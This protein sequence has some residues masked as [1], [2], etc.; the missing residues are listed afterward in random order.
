MSSPCKEKP[1]THDNS[2]KETDKEFE[3][4]EPNAPKTNALEMPTTESLNAERSFIDE[5]QTKLLE[6]FGT[7]ATMAAVD[8]DVEKYRRMI[9]FNTIEPEKISQQES[10]LELLISNGICD[11]E[12]FKIFIAEPDLHKDK[13]SQILDSLYCVNTL[14]P[15][16]YENE[17][18]IEWV[19]SIE[20]VA[21]VAGPEDIPIS[22][23]LSDG[24]LDT[25]QAPSA[26]S[27]SDTQTT[28]EEVPCK[29]DI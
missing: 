9:P 1:K 21:N 3:V 23:E 17:S 7:T 4:T 6:T 26:D 11:D 19:N 14:M 15:I 8:G 13:A 22:N 20:S 5:M 28:V 2:E 29:C 27:I 10:I 18:A 16:V 25:N 12:T 24:L